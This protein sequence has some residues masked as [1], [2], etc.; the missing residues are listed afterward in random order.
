MYNI[1]YIYQA[2]KWLIFLEVN[3]CGYFG[4]LEDNGRIVIKT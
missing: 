2:K 4:K 1:P 3:L